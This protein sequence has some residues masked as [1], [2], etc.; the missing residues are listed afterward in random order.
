MWKVLTWKCIAFSLGL[1][2]TLVQKTYP[3]YVQKMCADSSKDFVPEHDPVLLR[4][5]L[6]LLALKPG[7]TV[8][9]CTLGLAGHSLELLKA[10]G[11]EG[12]LYAFDRDPRNIQVAQKRLQKSGENFRILHD[13]FRSLTDRLR[14]EGAS[15][16]DAILF[17]LG[18]S[19]PHL[20]D[21][22]RGFSFQQEGP[23][24]M[25]FDPNHSQTAADI[26]DHYS[27]E[28]LADIF[29]HF[30]E[31]RSSRKLARAIVQHRKEAPIQTTG[32][33]RALVEEV[34]DR[35]AKRVMAQVFQA[36]R[37][38][39]NEELMALELGLNQAIELLAPHGRMVVI[40]YHSLEDRL[41][42]QVFKQLAIDQRDP[43]DPFGRRVLK[44][45][46][47]SLLNKKPIVPGPEEVARN[48]RARSAK[49]RAIQKL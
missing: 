47:L 39:V 4:E 18:L 44:S 1:F 21:A 43:T 10:V 17:D 31:L 26:L 5:T 42:K 2:S 45:K 25:R 12:Q 6:E 7:E 48:P 8:V 36:L 28:E 20:D 40:S 46:S 41:V 22:E 24:D 11:S 32:D 34:F 27:E 49:L 3:Q 38:E 14:R 29:F 30:G 19:S 15:Q 33:L 13:S 35:F 16:V 9:D 23:L 37:M